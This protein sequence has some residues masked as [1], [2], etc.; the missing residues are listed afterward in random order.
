MS[1]LNVNQGS[2][3]INPLFH[4][5]YTQE[6]APTVPGEPGETDTLSQAAVHKG[7]DVT[8]P[9]DVFEVPALFTSPTEVVALPGAYVITA[10]NGQRITVPSPANNRDLIEAAAQLIKEEPHIAGGDEPSILQYLKS[11]SD[12]INM[13]EAAL[14]DLN[15]VTTE[16]RLARARDPLMGYDDKMMLEEMAKVSKENP[17]VLGETTG[18]V[19]KTVAAPTGLNSMQDLVNSL[20]DGASV[21][22]KIGDTMTLLGQLE[23]ILNHPV[24]N[25]SGGF[26]LGNYPQV[27]IALQ[28]LGIELPNNPGNVFSGLAQRMAKDNKPPY[29]SAEYKEF[30]NSMP[31]G[32]EVI[33][34]ADLE[35]IIKKV[36]DA[37]K[38]QAGSAY[39]VLAKPLQNLFGTSL[40]ALP[41]PPPSSKLYELI[42]IK[43]QLEDLLNVMNNHHGHIPKYD[44]D[45]LIKRAVDLGLISKH[46]DWR[47]SPAPEDLNSHDIY[48]AIQTAEKKINRLGGEKYAETGVFPG[49]DRGGVVGSGM[50]ASGALVGGFTSSL[51]STL[52]QLFA[53]EL[54]DSFQNSQLKPKEQ[55]NVQQLATMAIMTA[56][57]GDVIHEQPGESDQKG[58]VENL[59]NSVQAQ[60][61]SGAAQS[62]VDTVFGKSSTGGGLSAF[63]DSIMK[64]IT[65]S[66][67]TNIGVSTSVG[68][69]GSTKQMNAVLDSLK[70]NEALAKPATDAQAFLNMP[71]SQLDNPKQ[72]DAY[73]KTLTNQSE[74]VSDQKLEEQETL[75]KMIKL[76]KEILAELTSG[77]T[78]SKKLDDS[79]SEMSQ[80]LG[81]TAEQNSI[82]PTTSA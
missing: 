53:T 48:V 35:G 64:S 1:D 43:K 31:A 36:A 75:R 74:S 49:S 65:Q 12:A 71:S 4:P 80:V 6:I 41:L 77:G 70:T 46:V 45:K 17:A 15:Q 8:L 82:R 63:Q 54:S 76:L 42:D 23:Y 61:D 20:V 73:I 21:D 26:I 39:G 18:K 2:S 10:N 5:E 13:M 3:A 67:M 30:A 25:V 32:W 81:T 34:K 66:F 24:A 60:I 78:V 19:G 37:I 11:L 29:N 56:L 68:S 52:D 59:K 9:P 33:N 27:A 79:A 14:R 16:Q 38:A 28:K 72:F 57:L 44:Y 55:Q 69:S 22:P 50:V 62:I 51:S 58:I 40:F 47:T 7:K